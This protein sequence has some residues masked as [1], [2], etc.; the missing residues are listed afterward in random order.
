MVATG[1]TGEATAVSGRRRSSGWRQRSAC[2]RPRSKRSG[3][4]WGWRGGAYSGA[5]PTETEA[6][7]LSFCSLEPPSTTALSR[8][9]T[10]YRPNLLGRCT[11]VKKKVSDSHPGEF[12]HQGGTSA[13]GRGFMESSKNSKKI[14]IT[15]LQFYIFKKIYSHNESITPEHRKQTQK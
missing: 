14:L 6:P 9:L 15:I 1:S 8:L 11:L 10:K 5:P 12:V 4:S 7:P 2:W 13:A 3:N